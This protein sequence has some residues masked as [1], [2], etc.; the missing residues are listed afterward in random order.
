MGWVGGQPNAHVC[1]YEVDKWTFYLFSRMFV[2]QH[3]IKMA[4]FSE[5]NCKLFLKGYTL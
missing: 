2:L 1:P 4:R 3:S 5:K